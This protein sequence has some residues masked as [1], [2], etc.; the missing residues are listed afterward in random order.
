[1]RIE[2]TN[3]RSAT[4]RIPI[5]LFFALILFTFALTVAAQD[6]TRLSATWQVQKYDITASLPSSDSDRNLTA[7]ATLSLRNVS[8]RPAASLTL[9][10]SSNATVSSVTVNGTA[11][12]FT[13]AEEKL[14]SASLQ[15]I[16]IRMPSVAPA[17][18][19]SAV[20]DYKLNVKENSGL[21]ALSPT[22]S[23][24]LPLSFWYPTPNSWYFAR[25]A[26]YAG[27]KVQV[28]A[29]GQTVVSSGK[30]NAGSFDQTLLVQPFFAAGN[31][32]K[33]TSQGVDIFLPKGSS[34]EEKKRADELAAILAEAKTFATTSFGAGP[35]TPLR[36]VAVKRGGGFASGGTLL[37]DES[38]FRR[39][40]LDSGT[41]AGAADAVAKLWFADSLQVSGDGYGAIREGL[42]RFAATQFLESKYGK[43][44]ADIE[45][46]RQR[47]SY[48]TVSQRDAPII[49]VAP[50]DDYYYSTVAYKGAMVWRL[51]HRRI[52]SDEF[53]KRIR[54]GLE[55]KAVTLAELR[56]LFPE[57][58][59][60][61][62]SMF[63]KITDTN[64]LVGLPQAGAGETKVAL[65]N[66]GTID[67]T[68][69]VTATFAN[70]EKMSAPATIRA[71]SFGE[72]TFKSPN[73]VVKLEVD[74][75]KLFP[76]VDYSD[77]IAPRESTDSD[78]LL[79]V[80]K[81]FDKQEFP[82]AETTAKKVLS[83]Y[84]SFD[85]VRVLLGRSLLAQNKNS[86]AEREFKIVLDEKLPTGRS[87]AW[88]NLGLAEVAQ[89]SGQG[90][91][92]VKLAE[93]AI[94]ADADFGASL[95][96]R[97]L[98]NKVNAT[99]AVPEDIKTF[100][101]NMDRIAVSNRKADLDA[102][103]VGGE[104]SRF[105]SGVSGQ[106][107]EWKTQPVH[108]D[109][110]GADTYLVETQM[111]VKL[112]NREVETGMAVYRMVRT[113]SGLKLYSVDIFEVR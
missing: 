6:D 69:N 56:G 18:T 11:V 77:D 13:K 112:L 55:D 32:E 45:R 93:D 48:S 15:R 72:I 2:L 24:F 95:G 27:V 54:T 39:A 41:V 51:L 80:K 104:A 35:D 36:I 53:N 84:P 7:K 70:G 22:G 37:V 90:A 92:A 79:A 62:D 59:E 33:S 66:T 25:G 12:D 76:Q 3:R 4:M 87:I 5:F 61:L 107:V 99:T 100:F 98:R 91:A 14:G 105:V 49:Q 26:D 82:L 60:F 40:K 58:K 75:E 17:G 44:V 29:P 74:S 108:V 1:M 110:F 52:G 21:S 30:E 28:N 65:R 16:A 19:I 106:V 67:A 109:Q 89:R 47:N 57:Q 20:V 86:E 63:D 46:M 97:T 31:Y 43:P 111:S 8:A 96:A 81:A 38:V 94:R 42:A 9:R 68:V 23:Q 10:I 102:T 85:E 64:L 50:L 101:T 88:S 83:D 34:A 71:A 103:V 78:L 73:K 113:P